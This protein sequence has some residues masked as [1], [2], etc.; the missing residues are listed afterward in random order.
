MNAFSLRLVK[1][2]RGDWGLGGQRDDGDG[3]VREMI[4]DG[5]GQEQWMRCCG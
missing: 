3:Q 4:G 2:T 5:T 1:S